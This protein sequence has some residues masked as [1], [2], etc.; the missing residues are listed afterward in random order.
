M[1]RS[2][3]NTV[4]QR[5]FIPGMYVFWTYVSG[6][7]KTPDQM[8]I[9]SCLWNF[10]LHG[11][12]GVVVHTIN[13]D[14][15]FL[16]LSSKLCGFLT[17]RY[18]RTQPNVMP[19]VRC[20]DSLCVVS[21]H[22]P[23]AIMIVPKVWENLGELI[24][25]EPTHTYKQYCKEL[26]HIHHTIK[27]IS[28]VAESYT[29]AHILYTTTCFIAGNCVVVISEANTWYILKYNFVE[30]CAAKFQPRPYEQ[31]TAGGRTESPPP[32]EPI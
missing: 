3:W 14:L 5:Y 12:Y 20:W 17:A 6:F 2:A 1:V 29:P 22:R 18:C 26:L 8:W 16:T 15:H 23:C 19:P 4:F 31:P 10:L 11:P 30:Y 13:F 28:H 25:S 32:P 9:L 7:R 21:Y 24:C 27:H